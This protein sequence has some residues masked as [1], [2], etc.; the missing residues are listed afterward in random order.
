MQLLYDF[1]ILRA[2]IFKS[3]WVFLKCPPGQNSTPTMQ[4]ADEVP[5][6]L[7]FLELTIYINN[8]SI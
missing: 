1:E 7:V 3:S 6:V 4:A 2:L 8:L 5:Q